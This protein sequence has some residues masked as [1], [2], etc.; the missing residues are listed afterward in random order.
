MFSVN[1]V[2]R[3]FSF[4]S[5]PN[6]SKPRSVLLDK[7]KSLP[8]SNA[9]RPGRSFSAESSRFSSSPSSKQL[10]FQK[11]I[12]FPP[13][14]QKKQ[15]QQAWPLWKKVVIGAGAVLATAVLIHVI[16]RNFFSNEN[17]FDKSALAQSSLRANKEG[18]TLWHK[19]VQELA[20]GGWIEWAGEA[21]FMGIY[22]VKNKI[23]E[24]IATFKPEDER[25]LR[26]N[27]RN[28]KFRREFPTS[29]EI[30][31]QKVSDQGLSSER[32]FLTNQFDLGDVARGPEGYIAILE[33]DQFFDIRKSDGLEKLSKKGYLQAW[34]SDAIPI[35]KAASKEPG[36]LDLSEYSLLNN[37][38]INEIQKVGILDFISFNADRTSNN[39]LISI[40]SNGIPHLIPIDHDLTFPCKLE[41]FYGGIFTHTVAEKPF[42]KESR[43]L[44]NELGSQNVWELIMAEGFPEQVARNTKAL[45]ITLKSFSKDP[46]LTLADIYRFAQTTPTL[47][48]GYSVMGIILSEI[49]KKILI[50]LKLGE[51]EIESIK[52]RLW[53]SPNTISAKERQTFNLYDKY[54]WAEFQKRINAEVL[55]ISSKK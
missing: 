11:L 22:L 55:K 18:V 51:N 21:S 49:H 10:L 50:L 31:K 14:A 52:L 19:V 7:S 15:K 27:C 3:N 4:W 54:F 43:H 32:Q 39:L 35:W 36:K 20:E 34:I 8:F 33:S 40:D 17:L 23:G 46:R 48:T 38:P 42:T 2:T 37:V 12:P 29:E 45:V 9:Q 24:T 16:S 53:T 6:R 28:P 5:S 1:S 26:P 30:L 13:S 47:S 44:I 25:F 41:T